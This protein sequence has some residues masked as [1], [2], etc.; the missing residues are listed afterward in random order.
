MADLADWHITDS[1]WV[2]VFRDPDRRGSTLLNFAVDDLDTHIAELATRGIT[3]GAVN[4]TTKNAKVATVTDPHGNTI[5][6]EN[7]CN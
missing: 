5:A 6:I 1:A 4:T 7:P 2:S 3:V